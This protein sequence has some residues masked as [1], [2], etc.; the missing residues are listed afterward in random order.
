[1][2]KENYYFGEK[3]NEAIILFQKETDPKEKDRL[4]REI[5]WPAF[6]K[7]ATY[8]YQKLPVR[9]NDEVIS[10]CIVHLYEQI[11]KYDAEKKKQAFSYFNT[12][13][14]NFL[15]Q[16]LKFEARE[17]FND[18]ELANVLNIVD[19]SE[20]EELLDEGFEKDFESREFIEL[21]KQQLRKWQKRASKE[22]EI[23]VMSALLE[24]FENAE[25]ID[26]YKKKA[27]YFYIREMTNLNSKQVAQI[28]GKINKRFQNFKKK[29]QKGDI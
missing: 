6:E 18:Q 23:A 3:E 9:K 24:I 22:N 12:I 2:T 1:M 29:Y 20:S 10:D 19:M 8:W 17:I 14:R 15:F 13:A 4:I 11:T 7:L 27:I 16:K 21:F 26:I 28:L 25:N 5:I